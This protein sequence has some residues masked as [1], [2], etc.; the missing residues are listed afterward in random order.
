MDWSLR[1]NLKS[2]FASEND[3]TESAVEG[4]EAVLFAK[5]D[6]FGFSLLV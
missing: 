4:T 1:V 3:S 6:V 2:V 5:V